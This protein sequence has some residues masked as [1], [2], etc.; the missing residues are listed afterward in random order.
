MTRALPRITDPGPQ[1]LAGYLAA[2]SGGVSP[3]AAISAAGVETGRQW[4]A[5]YRWMEALKRN[6]AAESLS[7]GTFPPSATWRLT[8]N[9]RA[10]GCMARQRPNA[11]AGDQRTGEGIAQASGAH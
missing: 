10:R 11:A 5:V 2:A 6:G 4:R 8:G 1:W 9:R 3:R 7:H